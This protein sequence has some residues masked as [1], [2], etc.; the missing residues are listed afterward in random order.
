MPKPKTN[1][2]S[3]MQGGGLGVQAGKLE[4]VD[5]RFKLI[6][7]TKKDGSKVTPFCALQFDLYQL[8][9]EWD[10]T[11][12]SEETGPFQKEFIVCW[13]NKSDGSFKFRPG[14]AE[15][16][17]DEEVEDAGDELDT[18]GPTLYCDDN[19]VPFADSDFGMFL[20]S[21]EKKGFKAEVNSQGWAPNYI[22][23]KFQVESV[24]PTELCKELGIKH[25]ARDKEQPVWKVEDI[26]VKPYEGKKT[27]GTKAATKP[28]GK[29]AAVKETVDEE[30]NNESAE[31]EVNPVT[32]G[33]LAAYGQLN[34]GKTM[35]R[36]QLQ[37]QLGP[38]MMNKYK[39]ENG[40]KLPMGVQTGVIG[41]V[42]DDEKLAATVGYLGGE[43]SGKGD[44]AEVT[45][46]SE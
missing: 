7:R 34:P 26:H 43:V 35:T 41:D 20:A 24:T 11:P 18:E 5:A 19:S 46:A 12:E 2:G 25:S 4:V 8:D 39:D 10:R 32:A 22:G 21:L 9:D 1:A 45:F 36:K 16:A 31:V 33:V 40:K 38:F 29:A 3:L 15:S 28:N 23:M 42:R 44:K 37:T 14:L 6:G 30:E 17:T 13:S 27:A